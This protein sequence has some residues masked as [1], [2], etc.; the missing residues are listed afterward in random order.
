MSRSRAS[1]AGLPNNRGREDRGDGDD[2]GN[3]Y[4]LLPLKG[5][6]APSNSD[7]YDSKAA[8][9][10]LN[11]N[12]S[13]STLQ[14]GFLDGN[15]GPPVDPA[16]AE[17]AAAEVAK[18]AARAKKAMETAPKLDPLTG[19]YP[20]IKVVPKALPGT[21]VEYDTGLNLYREHVGF[22]NT[23]MNT[24]A[25]S[26]E[27]SALVEDIGTSDPDS[28]GGMKFVGNGSFNE[29][30]AL[31]EGLHQRVLAVA[32][33][34]GLGMNTKI[35]MR[36]MQSKRKVRPDV[37]LPKYT[38]IQELSWAE[39]WYGLIA[40]LAG[41]GV[42]IFA[43]SWTTHMA[44][45]FIEQG[46]SNLQDLIDDKHGVP[47][48]TDRE[49][50]GQRRGNAYAISLET[51]MRA[52]GNIGMVLA[53]MKPENIV[54]MD[55]STLKFI[56]FDPKYTVILDN[57]IG[58]DSECVEFINIFLLLS[59]MLCRRNTDVGRGLLSQVIRRF[60]TLLNTIKQKQTK[61]C[62]IFLQI[63]KNNA[64][65]SGLGL[66]ATEYPNGLASEVLYQA[67]HYIG[68]WDNPSKA[69]PPFSYNEYKPIIEQIAKNVLLKQSG[70]VL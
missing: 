18:A 2:R 32:G 69:C 1:P 63:V 52:T 47:A 36:R 21:S 70:L 35:G 27:L 41:I 6:Q 19:V 37:D 14:D 11:D 38:R 20:V 60:E 67:G 22:G 55:E 29:F 58:W 17:K 61:L 30:Y 43:A 39:L 54:V 13:G 33:G 31:S 48:L 65:N 68:W 53:D 50:L 16:G 7:V 44:V 56:D 10:A 28:Y 46:S 42:R 26:A 3:K 24:V 62:N 49:R 5:Q 12:K 15:Y 4:P 66:A 8:Q 64:K 57:G 23:S 34:D 45:S 25:Y 40:H 59:Y 51:I 9:Q